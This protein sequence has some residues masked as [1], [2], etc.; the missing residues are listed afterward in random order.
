MPIGYL[1]STG[2]LATCTAVALRPPRPRRSSPFRASFWLAFL[3]NELPFV[4]LFLLAGATALALADHDVS[5][6]AGWAVVGLAALAAAGLVLVAW[7]AGATRP[8]LE[9]ALGDALGTPV[10]LTRRLPWARIL[11]APYLFRRRDVERVA[12][13]RYGNAGRRNALD[14]YRHRSHPAGAPV[15]VH[16]HGGTFRSGKK[17]RQAR[18][19]LYRLASQGWV[20]VS[21]NYRRPAPYADQLLDVGRVLAWVRAGGREYGADPHVVFAAGSSA[22][23]HLAATAALTADVP[24][25]A[26]VCLGGYYGPADGVRPADHARE[27][28]PPFLVVH[29]DRDTLVVAEDARSFAEQLRRVS[30]R[31]VVYA[32]LPWGQ[33]SFDLFHSI[34]FERVVDA[35]E[36][37]A[38]WARSRG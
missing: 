12:N 3:V 8:A 38:A 24:V 14:V 2:L 34:R 29:G 6:P 18:A 16:F 27:D 9:R 7:R 21:A 5:G 25:A 23:A 11:V 26:V 37:F 17:N 13:L 36:A 35:V 4:G 20:C 19:L 22:G 30:R 32:A 28:A 10:R 31:P 15:L 33:H 1:I